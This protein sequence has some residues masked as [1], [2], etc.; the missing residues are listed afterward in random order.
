MITNAVKFT[1]SGSIYFG[2]SVH[3]KKG[4]LEFTVEDTG[5]GISKD[6]LK[7]IFDRFRQIEA[8]ISPELTGLGLGLSITKAYVEMLGGKISSKISCR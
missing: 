1:E 8:T 3:K 5:N 6:Y 2:Y 4:V 7:V